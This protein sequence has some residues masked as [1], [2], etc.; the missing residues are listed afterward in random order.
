MSAEVQA[1]TSLSWKEIDQPQSLSKYLVQ[2]SFRKLCMDLS[3]VFIYFVSIPKAFIH[4]CAINVWITMESL[5]IRKRGQGK[6]K[7]LCKWEGGQIIYA[8]YKLNSNHHFRQSDSEDE[9]RLYFS[10]PNY[11]LIYLHWY[12]QWVLEW[13]E[14]TPLGMSMRGFSSIETQL[15]RENHLNVGQ[16]LRLKKRSVGAARCSAR[17]GNYP[18]AW[19]WIPEPTW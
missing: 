12:L 17:E 15:R 4:L 13:S 1:R 3:Q 16:I 19:T 14:D 18:Q 9:V 6:R 11:R 5:D 7:S 8:L 10:W 2:K